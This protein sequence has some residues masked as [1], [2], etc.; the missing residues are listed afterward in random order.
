MVAVFALG[1]LIWGWKH[2]LVWFHLA[3][4]A[5][6][7]F[8]VTLTWHVLKTRQ[9]DITSQ[10]WLFSAVI[11]YLGNI[12]VLLFGVP[13]LTAKVSLWNALSWWFEGIGEIFHWLARTF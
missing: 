4:G 7:G 13:L 6:Y 11:I 10:G 8:H 9:S 12:F 5:A 3:F 2:L 1:N